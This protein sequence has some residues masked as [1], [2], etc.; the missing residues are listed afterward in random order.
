MSLN[1]IAIIFKGNRGIP[2]R[3]I[4]AVREGFPSWWGLVLPPDSQCPY[5]SQSYFMMT[6]IQSSWV[7]SRQFNSKSLSVNESSSLS[8]MKMQGG[9]QKGCSTGAVPYMGPQFLFFLFGTVKV[10]KMHLSF[11]WWWTRPLSSSFKYEY[12]SLREL[13]YLQSSLEIWWWF[14]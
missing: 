9:T 6:S 8:G 13:L 5:H 11:S 10:A 4:W 7:S 14:A 3:E 2:S 12:L 1:F